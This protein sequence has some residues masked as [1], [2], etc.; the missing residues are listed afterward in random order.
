[1]GTSNPKWPGLLGL[2]FYAAHGTVHVLRGHPEDLLWVC[3]LAS[4]AVGI[5]WLSSSPTAN[6]IGV[7]WLS[8]G[9]PLWAL[10][11]ATGG[12]FFPTSALTHVG[13]LALGVLGVRR[14]GMPP[15]AWW[16]AILALAAVQQLCRW[17]TPVEANVN[18]SRAVW[19]G[20]ERAFP[21]YPAY[22]ALLLTGCGALF[23][24]VERVTRMRARR[25]DD[26]VPAR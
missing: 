21:S 20:W 3:H 9:L 19:K 17:T 16:K 22:C 23:F 2:A 11:L 24:A 13:G 4:L 8:F 7:M 25:S 14:F 18:L 10:D 26:A 5:G 6:A 1:L 12:E 15:G